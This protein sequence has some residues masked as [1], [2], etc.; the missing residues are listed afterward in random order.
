MSD[1]IEVHFDPERGHLTLSCSEET[2]ARLRDLVFTEALIPEI[3]GP[4]SLAAWHIEI[5]STPVVLAKRREHVRWSSALAVGLA[6][7]LALLGFVVGLWT[8]L[9]WVA[10]R[11]H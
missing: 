11:F 7:V 1:D 6:S 4:P 3:V 8:V 2:F 10:Q 5:E 9:R